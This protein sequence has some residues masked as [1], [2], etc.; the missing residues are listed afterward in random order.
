MVP[1]ARLGQKSAL[2]NYITAE[3]YDTAVGDR[4]PGCM[5]G[6][7]EIIARSEIFLGTKYSRLI[8]LIALFKL[9]KM[10]SL[11][12]EQTPLFKSLTCISRRVFN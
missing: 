1:A 8:E 11:F 4:F 6:K 9:N 7:D 3:D 10:F 12:P 2:G 5:R